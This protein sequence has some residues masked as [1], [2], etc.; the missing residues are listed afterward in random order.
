MGAP[1]RIN[2]MIVGGTANTA[3]RVE[4]LAKEPAPEEPDV[5]ITA[6][7]RTIDTAGDGIDAAPIGTRTIRGRER[8]IG[9]RRL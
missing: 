8:G 1:G 3:S 5:A 4:R 7:A 6:S 9:L 2:H